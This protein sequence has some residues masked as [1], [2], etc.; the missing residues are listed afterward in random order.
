MIVLARIRVRDLTFDERQD[1]LAIDFLKGQVCC[2]EVFR[3]VLEKPVSITNYE[4]R[5]VARAR[6]N[7]E[8]QTVV[9]AQ[10]ELCDHHARL[11]LQVE[12]GGAVRVGSGDPIAMR[13]QPCPQVIC[14]R[15]GMRD[16]QN[17]VPAVPKELLG[18][19]TAD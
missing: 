14:E 9:F 19:Q 4:D 10:L 13:A 12:L 5:D 1:P 11:H 3:L 6:A 16:D 8:V 17:L 7:C 18:Y 2:A 15:R